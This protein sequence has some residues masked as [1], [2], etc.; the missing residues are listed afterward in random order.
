MFKPQRSNLKARV[1]SIG[2]LSPEDKA[3]M[4]Q[5]MRAYYDAITEPRFLSDLS[6]KDAVILLKDRGNMIQGFSTLVNVSVKVEGKT[7][8]AVFSG[9][10]VIDRRYWGQGALGKPFLRYL[11]IERIKSPFAPLYWLLISKGYKTYLMMAN[12]FSEHYPR[13]EK[14]TPARAKLILDSFYS[15]LYPRHYD[16]RTGLIEA[17]GEACRLKP[18]VAGIPIALLKSNPRIA[19]FQRRNPRWHEGAEMACIARMTL[20]M[21]FGYAL[22]V[23]IIDSVMKPLRRLSLHLF[24]LSKEKDRNFR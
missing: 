21:P 23:M 2:Q 14:P 4:F 11:F 12:N 6:N 10:T 24:P 22:K 19:F 16:A 13:F 1:V 17:Q 15:T 3:R 8:R 20:L 7:L 9:D 18:G 5:L